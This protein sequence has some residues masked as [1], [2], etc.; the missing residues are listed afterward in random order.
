[1]AV[2]ASPALSPK[3]LTLP[4]VIMATRLL[5]PLSFRVTSESTAPS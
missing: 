1:M 2:A 5:P 3:D 4:S